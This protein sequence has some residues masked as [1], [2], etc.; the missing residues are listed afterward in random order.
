MAIA[1]Q[2]SFKIL[3]VLSLFL[4]TSA[5]ADILPQPGFETQG[6]TIET[7]VST[8]GTFRNNADITW[9]QSSELLDSNLVL[10][11]VFIDPVTEEIVE[12]W[13]NQPEP[14]LHP[15]TE[16]QARLVYSE[17]TIAASGKMD[18]SKSS[19]IETKEQPDSSNNIEMERLI[20]Y[21]G[22]DGHHVVSTEDLMLSTVGTPGV[23][24][25]GTSTC[26]FPCTKCGCNECYP[27]FCNFVQA[28][29][30]IDMEIA[31]ASSSAKVRNV[32]GAVEDE[33]WPPIPNVDGNVQLQYDIRVD[34]LSTQPS[35]G[36]VSAYFDS[37]IMEGGSQCPGHYEPIEI[38][39]VSDRISADGY[40]SL[41]D[42]NINYE[43]GL[44]RIR[45]A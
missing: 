10:V 3:I 45:E 32:G 40:V 1:S 18:Y 36:M 17:D 44:I 9:K 22:I 19:V 29:S 33:N 42:R 37:L 24:C 35:V 43:S 27:A 34:K 16:V 8:Q 13:E 14:P 39:E 15:L 28:G 21:D 7:L 25:E 23:P 5:A 2:K 12:V 20:T 4:I 31:S 41:F 26:V 11:D 6:I 30:E 38:I